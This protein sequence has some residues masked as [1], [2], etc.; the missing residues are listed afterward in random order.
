MKVLTMYSQKVSMHALVFIFFNIEPNLTV[1]FLMNLSNEIDLIIDRLERM[2]SHKIIHFER[3][4][5]FTDF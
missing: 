1:N 5:F 3:K 2:E 4:N